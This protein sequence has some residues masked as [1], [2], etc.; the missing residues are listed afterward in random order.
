L[1]DPAMKIRD[2]DVSTGKNEETHRQHFYRFLKGRDEPEWMNNLRRL[3][4]DRFLKMKWPTPQE[5]EWRRTDI[6]GINFSSFDPVKSD[7]PVNSAGKEAGTEE[8]N[9]QDISISD[10]DSDIYSGSVLFGG[11]SIARQYLK[12]E[13]REKGVSLLLLKD[14]FRTFPKETKNILQKSLAISEN[15]FQLWH[16]SMLSHGVL[17]YIPPYLEVEDPFYINFSINGEGSLSSPHVIVILDRGA[18]ATV[19]YKTH[20]GNEKRN[21][22]NAGADIV[23]SDSAGLNYFDVQNLNTSSLYISHGK[24]SINRDGYLNH[25]SAGLGSHI[26][27]SRFDGA[28]D[29][30]GSDALMSG[31]YFSHMDQHM[32]I[33]TVQR[34]NAP[35]TRSRAFYKGAVKDNARAVFQGLIEVEPAAALTDAYLTN[36]NLILGDGAR[37]DSIPSLKIKNNDVKCSHGST[38]GRINENE[39]FYLMTR[40]L[41][42]REAEKMIIMGYFEE[43]LEKSPGT[44]TDE[45]REA[46]LERIT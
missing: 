14:A 12:K 6:T 44:I 16:S 17:L 35:N 9:R 10:K 33:R 37:A 34:H 30:P 38:T 29:G 2:M 18:R 3:S 23:V 5:E 24:A 31:V 45:I 13:L 25:F 19:I 40:G 26:Y 32:D 1:A 42:K 4:W 39:V 11:A 27:K 22:C 8:I 36:K 28:L 46:V 20:S 41:S 7:E 15:R 21:L 43:V